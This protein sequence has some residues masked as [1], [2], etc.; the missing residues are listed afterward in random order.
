MREPVAGGR[1][2]P[3]PPSL[4]EGY[5]VWNPGEGETDSTV[6]GDATLKQG[7]GMS[8]KWMKIKINFES[9]RREVESSPY[10]AS[11]ISVNRR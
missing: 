4:P 3:A 1:K 8:R 6:Q 2:S 11:R 9:E 7:R 5:H 10:M